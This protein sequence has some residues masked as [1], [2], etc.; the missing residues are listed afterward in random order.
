MWE[1]YFISIALFVASTLLPWEKLNIYKQHS[2]AVTVK[3]PFARKT[4]ATWQSVVSKA[5][6][7]KLWDAMDPIANI[8]IFRKKS[9]CSLLP[10]ANWQDCKELDEQQFNVLKL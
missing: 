2:G 7:I 9:K 1:N 10:T 3:C 8:H 4:K 6:N 5:Q